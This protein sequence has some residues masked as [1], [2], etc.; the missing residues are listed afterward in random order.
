[1]L[2]ARYFWAMTSLRLPRGM[3]YAMGKKSIL[4]CLNYVLTAERVFFYFHFV[5]LISTSPNAT[6]SSRY[7]NNFHYGIAT[8]NV[9]LRKCHLTGKNEP[10][11]KIWGFHGSG[12]EEC[13]LLEYKNP[14]RTSQ[15]TH[16]ISVTESSQLMLCKI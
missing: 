11:C 16:Y 1:V 13:R 14:V 6:F 10:R 7:F 5:L 3:F 4:T 12:Y 2:I 8:H 9:S 15:E